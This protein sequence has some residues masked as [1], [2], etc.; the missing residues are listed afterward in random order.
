MC[1]IAGEFSMRESKHDVV[2]MTDF[3]RHRGPDDTGICDLTGINGGR[4]GTFGHRRLAIVDLSS[5][6]HQPMFS[7]DGHLTITYNGEIYNYAELRRGLEG[8]GMRFR[9]GSDTEVLLAGWSVMGPA[10]LPRLRGMFAFALW[11]SVKE[12]GYLVRDT[13]GIKP[14]YVAERDGD[15]L[16][17]SEVRALLAT[18][19]VPRMLSASAVSSYLSTGSV[20]EPLTIVEGISAVPAG[21]VIELSHSSA[22]FRAG[23]AVPFSEPFAESDIPDLPHRSHIHRIRN[24]LRDS[25]RYHLVSDVPVGVFLSGGIDSSAVAGLA[26]EVSDTRIESFTV[27]F[28]ESDFSEA[29]PARDAARRFGTNHH[30]VLLSGADLLNALPD[31]FGAMDQPS[32]D[33]LNTF[34]VSRA[35]RSFG[36]KVVLSGLGGDELFGGYP[37]F[38]RAKYVAPLW[39]LPSAIRKLGAIGADPFDDNRVSRMSALLRDATPAGGAYRASRTLFGD[40]QIARLMASAGH[41]PAGGSFSSDPRIGELTLMQQVSMHEL[42]GYMRNTLLRD[43][44]VFSMAHGLELRVPLVDVDVARVAHQAAA[45]LDPARGAIKPMLIEAVRDLLS[46]EMLNRPKKGFTL[47]FETWMRNEL[48]KEVD[49]E[50]NGAG[51]AQVR[52]AQRE[53]SAVWTAFRNR[54]PGMNWSRPWSLYTLMRWA[55]HNSISFEP[56]TSRRTPTR[57]T[58][59]LAG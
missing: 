28:D 19:R 15:I 27:T 34:V 12:R 36:L 2:R 44:D 30:E 32:L 54:Q 59:S 23:D 29:E 22:R 52:L 10:F 48:F 58:L 17:A 9:S 37:S 56:G 46:P 13:F 4:F 11:D 6:G 26:S 49:S 24:A 35:V 55:R 38:Y 25:V 43:S 41:D 3:I 8:Q 5:A 53:V 47:P 7:P 33:G 18:G 51:A 16:F 14:L 50:L 1:G 31:V 20:A 45:T 40:R 21:C 39:R 57:P 42:T